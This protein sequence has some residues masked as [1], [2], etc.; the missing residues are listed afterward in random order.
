MR[1]RLKYAYY[2]RCT[3]FETDENGSVTVVH[4]EYDPESRGGGT[5]T[6]ERSEVQY[7]GCPRDTQSTRR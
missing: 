6:G 5:P 3:G 4:A 7:T 2:V 1:V